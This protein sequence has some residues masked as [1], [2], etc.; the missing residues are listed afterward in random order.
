MSARKASPRGLGAALAAL[1]LLVPAVSALVP[2]DVVWAATPRQPDLQVLAQAVARGEDRI[3]PAHLRGLLTARRGDFTLVDIRSPADFAQGHIQG[4]INVPLA[5]LFDPAELV[6]LRKSPQVIVVSRQ[7]DQQAQAAA[8]L[9]VAGVPALELAGGL[10]AWAHAVDAWSASRE[11]YAI[12]RALNECPQAE[13][14]PMP[15]LQIP[16]TGTGATAPAPAPAAPPV[17][18][19]TPRVNLKG[20]CS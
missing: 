4:A 18:H 12:V 7:I 16:P 13:T 3:T 17:R 2:A 14:S 10:A 5:R 9:R 11:D 19:G 15:S 8:L 1:P 6:R 20:M